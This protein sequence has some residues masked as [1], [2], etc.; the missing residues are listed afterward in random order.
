MWQEH[1]RAHAAI[2]HH[3]LHGRYEVPRAP[4]EG[5]ARLKDE[6][7]AGMAGAEPVQQVDQL[8]A[9][10]FGMGHQVAAA[11]VEPGD[12][13]E[14]A[15]EMRLD[16]FERP[17]QM[18]GARLAEHV[19]VQALDS[20]GQ[21]AELRRRHAEAR[22]RHT[23][24]IEVGFH[25]RILRIDP[26]SA[27]YALRAGPRAEALVLRHRIEGDV[28]A[29]PHD[30]P[31]IAV[32]IDR[33]VG[34]GRTS[35]LLEHEAR[36]GGRAG[37]GSVGVTGQFG[38][39]TP[40]GARLERHDDFGAR[41]AAHLVDLRQIGVEQLFVQHVAGR[42]DLLKIDH[43][44]CIILMCKIKKIRPK[45]PD[46]ASLFAQNRYL[47]VPIGNPHNRRT[48]NPAPR[49]D[50]RQPIREGTLPP[51]DRKAQ[52]IRTIA[53]AISARS[54]RRP[55]ARGRNFIFEHSDE[56]DFSYHIFLQSA[57]Y[58]PYIFIYSK[59]TEN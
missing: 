42:R 45:A 11:H 54:R 7:Q 56:K 39:N 51:T 15:A 31:E 37:R 5:A 17:A 34:V 19:E 36:L 40:H 9:V 52:E 4:G 28:V 49:P 23:R 27:R 12:A 21:L 44:K 59:K 10:V 30:L 18:L 55:A 20:L 57:D 43:R 32:G 25:G 13:V 1:R 41:P 2:H 22:T 58:E 33:S 16:R 38:E 29:A 48:R 53:P 14:P 3:V 50:R 35:V 24:I 6:P 26:Q 47:Y 46:I 8:L